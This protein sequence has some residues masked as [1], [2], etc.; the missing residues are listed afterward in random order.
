[1]WITWSKLI[2]RHMRSL[3]VIVILIMMV[4]IPW[5]IISVNRIWYYSPEA[6]LGP[7]ILGLP[8]EELA[9]FIID[10]LLVGTLTIILRD[11]LR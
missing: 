10:G 11:K 2:R 1:M 5:E 6:I 7:R 3:L 8:I 4:S 9:F